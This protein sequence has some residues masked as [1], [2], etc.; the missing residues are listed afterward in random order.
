MWSGIKRSK[1][2]TPPPA[3]VPSVFLPGESAAEASIAKT[4]K[5]LQALREVRDQE[6]KRRDALLSYKRLL[7]EKGKHQLEPIVRKALDDLGFHASP[8]EIIPGTQYEIDGRTKAGSIPG[9]LE[10]K[11]SKNQISLDEF[12]PF[13]TKIL[14]DLQNT[15]IQS[16]GIL[17]AN[18]LCFD[19][20]EDG[21]GKW[22]FPLMCSM[23]RKGI[24]W[25]S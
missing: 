15:K 11:G 3:W 20:P 2:G 23:P 4:D 7:F 25:P 18:G 6:L 21:W 10:I 24:R 1:Q 5:E 17:I 14:A 12:T 8:G 9:I 19:K 16:K 13:V 22:Y